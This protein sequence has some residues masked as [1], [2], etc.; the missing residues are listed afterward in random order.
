ME[1]QSRMTI[2]REDQARALS[3]NVSF[4]GE[5]VQPRSPSEVAPVL[6]MAANL[7]HHH[8]RKLET[9][10]LLFEQRREGGR[11]YYQLSA[12]EFRHAHDLLPPEDPDEG[13][14]RD[15]RT[16]GEQFQAAFARS[17][18]VADGEG[19]EGMA[20]FGFKPA[21]PI[22]VLEGRATEPHPTH[23]DT[24]NLRLTPERY[25]RLAREL[26]HLLEEA[27][28]EAATA[29]RDGPGALCTV[30]VLAYRGNLLNADVWG[31]S[32]SSFLGAEEALT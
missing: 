11:V 6:G 2:T 16:L 12:R 17:W 21:A 32:T 9:L 15:L 24:V 13:L 29:G 25:R 14:T 1:Q 22:P 8:A 4:L 31:R 28:N 30:A 18:R 3:Q 19:D 23:F 10:G 20:V 26:S 5:F 7:A 27:V